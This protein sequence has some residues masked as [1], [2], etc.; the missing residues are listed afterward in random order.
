MQAP[1]APHPAPPLLPPLTAH[2]AAL[3][4]IAA[5][6]LF[7]ASKVNDEPRPAQH[8]AVEMFKR[9]YGRDNPLMRQRLADQAFTQALYASTFEAERAILYTVGFDFNIDLPHTHIAA[10]L[11]LP[12]FAYLQ[13]NVAFHQLAINFCND[14]MRKDGTLVLQ[15]TARDVALAIYYYVFKA[16]QRT[17]M[18]AIPQPQPEPDGVHWYVKEGL[19]VQQCSEIVRRIMSLYQDRTA[20]A[21]ASSQPAASTATTMLPGASEAGAACASAVHSGAVSAAAS[22][23]PQAADSAAG[24]AVDSAARPPPAQQQSQQ[25]RQQQQ[26]QPPAASQ[27]R[28]PPEPA[29]EAAPAKAARHDGPDGAHAAAAGMQRGQEPPRQAPAGQ[30]AATQPADSEPEEGELEEGELPE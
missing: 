6:A 1:L 11:R 24:G 21:A 28:G 17:S 12:R 18:A 27:K 23:A 15:Y 26:Q 16:A 8:L 13:K 5:G 25:Q 10:L 22:G 30:V 19:G 3:Q 2:T 14:I 7:L 20:A 29:G 4:I 9:W